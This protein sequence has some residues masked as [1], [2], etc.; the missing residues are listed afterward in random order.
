MT[1]S[2]DRQLAL[3]DLQ[4]FYTGA[5][6]KGLIWAKGGSLLVTEAALD[7]VGCKDYNPLINAKLAALVIVWGAKFYTLA[8]NNAL[9][10]EWLATISEHADNFTIGEFVK[11]LEE[12]EANYG[13][14]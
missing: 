2:N 3:Q 7:F 9:Y 14:S 12:K 4:R 11:D 10:A 8:S 13:S 6:S 5:C 1:T